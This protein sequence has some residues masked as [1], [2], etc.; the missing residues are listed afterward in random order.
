MLQHNIAAIRYPDYHV[1]AG[2]YPN[3]EKTQEAVQSVASRFPNVHMALCPHDGPT[4]KGDCL[5]WIYQHILLYEDE[6]AQRFD[7]ILLDA[8]RWDARPEVTAPAAAGDGTFVVVAAAAAGLADA[9]EFPRQF[10][11]HGVRLA[12]RVVAGRRNSSA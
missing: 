6:H 4:S 7:L 8:P 12:G 11:G 1:F 5:N 9:E 10:A 2:C 3:D